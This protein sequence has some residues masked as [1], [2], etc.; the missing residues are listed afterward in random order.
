MLVPFMTE[1]AGRAD[2]PPTLALAVGNA[3]PFMPELPLPPP[4]DIADLPDALAGTTFFEAAAGAANPLF[5]A[6]APTIS[7]T[8]NKP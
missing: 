6:N 7:R 3:L 4:G 2:V 8:D 1:L 5:V